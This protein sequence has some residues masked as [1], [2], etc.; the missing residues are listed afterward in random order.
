MEVWKRLH[1]QSMASSIMLCYIPVHNQ[2]DSA[3]NHFTFCVVVLLLN[4]APDFVV[5]WIEVRAV[6]H[7]EC[8]RSTVKKVDCLLYSVRWDT[9]L[10]KDKQHITYLR[11]LSCYDSRPDS[12]VSEWVCGQPS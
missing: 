6:W 8:R 11:L 5:S 3:S 9:L 4:Y 1:H 10:L 2:S 12:Q 7:D